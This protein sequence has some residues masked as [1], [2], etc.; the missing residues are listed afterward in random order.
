MGRIGVHQL[1]WLAGF[2]HL[3]KMNPET[4]VGY[5]SRRESKRF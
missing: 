1:C 2:R 4:A 5:D 3:R